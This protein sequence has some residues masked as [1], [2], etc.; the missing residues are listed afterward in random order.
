MTAV[1]L[2]KAFVGQRVS[3]DNFSAGPDF[4]CGDQAVQRD[5]KLLV[6]LLDQALIP[7]SGGRLR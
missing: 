2:E 4:G 5:F 3:E 6:I 7:G 1:K